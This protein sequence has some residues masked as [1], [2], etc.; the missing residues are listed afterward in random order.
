MFLEAKSGYQQP[1]S[2]LPEILVERPFT[3][4][5]LLEGQHVKVTKFEVHKVIH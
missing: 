1:K 5:Q 3:D 2:G 4:G